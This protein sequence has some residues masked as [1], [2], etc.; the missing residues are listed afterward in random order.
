MEETKK[1]IL[2]F[3]ANEQKET[4][5]SIDIDGNGEI[6]LTCVEC[7]RFIKLPKGTDA[8]GIKEYIVKHKASNEGQV[9]LEAIEAHKAKIL[10]DLNHG[11]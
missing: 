5:H 2:V 6:V 7:G 8:A 4:E 10:E 3:C 1:T 9:T 11:I